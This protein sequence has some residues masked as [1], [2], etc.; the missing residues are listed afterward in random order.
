MPTM[1]HT[2]PIITRQTVENGMNYAAYKELVERCAE[3]GTTTG[4]EQTEER[5]GFTKL[6]RQ[7][8]RRVEQTTVLAEKTLAALRLVNKETIWLTLVETWCGDAA[9]ITPV[10]QKMSEAQPLIQ[11]RFILRD[12]H[13][14][15]MDAFLT[16]GNRAIPRLI[17][18][19]ARTLEVIGD[20]GPRPEEGQ[21]LFQELKQAGLSHDDIVTRLH[22]WYADDKTLSAQRSISQ[23]LAKT[24][25]AS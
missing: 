9:Q 14:P 16:N 18:L 6:N 4:A 15:I 23:A 21:K 11:T 24:F 19:D 13:L 10:L 17:M 5:V 20:W 22:K 7:R 2:Q 25:Q 1:T 8:M 12:E 3:A